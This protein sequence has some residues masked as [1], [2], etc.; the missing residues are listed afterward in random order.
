MRIGTLSFELEKTDKMKLSGSQRCEII[1][2]IVQGNDLDLMLCAGYSLDN[3]DQLNN[4]QQSMNEL[5]S[6]TILI[7]EV[8]S[9]DQI[10]KEGHP[11]KDLKLGSYGS[12]HKMYAI[13]PKIEPINLG[14]QY[15]S[16]SSELN[17]K[18]DGANII[19]KFEDAFHEKSALS[20]KNCNVVALCCGEINILKGRSKVEFRS[21]IIEEAI[22]N[23]QIVVNPT[24][25]A[26]SNYGTLIAKR[27]FL[28]QKKNGLTRIYIS[29]SNWNTHKKTKNGKIIT[30]KPS[31]RTLHSVFLNGIE[32]IQ[33]S[34]NQD[35]LY[36]FRITEIDL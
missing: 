36:E 2:N 3:K 31:S 4:L 18:K 26:M 13:I 30:Q 25:D 8:Q 11:L 16:T 24:H 5:R 10:Q 22:F 19:K 21:K 20:F 15:F 12:K 33:Y 29:S 28:S 6:K 27:K 32:Q 34:Q 7:L 1:K 35:D 9:D 23:S 14:A 17:N